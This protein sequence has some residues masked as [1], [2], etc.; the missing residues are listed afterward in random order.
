M[1]AEVE[2]TD[3]REGMANSLVMRG[4]ATMLELMT[5]SFGEW[6]PKGL[7]IKS[8]VLHDQQV[9]L[10]IAEGV[11]TAKVRSASGFVYKRLLGQAD[12]TKSKDRNISLDESLVEDGFY[13]TLGH[14]AVHVLQG[15][16]SSRKLD[17]FGKQMNFIQKMVNGLFGQDEA[18]SNL[19]MN[20]L[21]DKKEGGLSQQFNSSIGPFGS[22]P[23]VKEMK[24]IRYLREGIEIQARIHQIIIDGYPRWGKVPANRD[25]FYAA[26]KNAGCKLPPEIEKHL[27]DLPANSSAKSFLSCA[28]GT[29][30]KVEEIDEVN[31]SFNKE[32]QAEFWNKVMPALYGDLIEL[33]GDKLGGKRMSPGPDVKADAS[34]KKSLAAKQTSPSLAS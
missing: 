27:E 26:M 31:D 18:T 29:C 10:G 13:S 14:E 11:L 25:E 22:D 33:Y 9:K 5:S 2:V 30:Y 1:L 7:D 15:D 23:W 12:S 8:N 17:T 4:H 3:K 20:R 19:I 34:I 21:I 28:K 24:R 32:G 6:P 16:N